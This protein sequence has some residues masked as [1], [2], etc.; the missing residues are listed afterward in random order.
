M[1]VDKLMLL[2]CGVG[3][4]SPGTLKSLLQ[5]HNSKATI[6]RC[7][8]FFIVQVSHPYMTTGEGQVL[9]KLGKWETVGSFWTGEEVGI[10]DFSGA[11]YFTKYNSV[12][13]ELYLKPGLFFFN[14]PPY[15]LLLWLG[16]YIELLKSAASNLGWSLGNRSGL[17][18]GFRSHMSR[19]N[20]WT[21][22]IA[23]GIV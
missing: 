11:I 12:F 23:K 2:N 10:K 7:S 14:S 18:I 8:A 19:K 16:I 15:P 5:H 21:H 9:Y 17:E 20:S 6:L 1:S 4:C 13:C 3:S 22:D